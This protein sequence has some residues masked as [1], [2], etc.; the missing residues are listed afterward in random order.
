MTRMKSSIG[1]RFY[2]LP[3]KDDIECWVKCCQSCAMT[4]R[5]HGRGRAPLI[6]ELAGAPFQRVTFD[7]IG[8]LPITETGKQ[9]ILVLVDYYTKWVEAYDL[10]DHKATTVADTITCNWIARLGVP[11]RLHCDNAQEFRGHVLKEVKELLGVK[12]KFTTPYRLQANGL[13][14]RTNQTIEGILRT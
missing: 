4:K 2:W 5:G 7:V 13:C 1:L 12:R 11:L 10:V 14:E 6:Q 9:F 3:M 8:P